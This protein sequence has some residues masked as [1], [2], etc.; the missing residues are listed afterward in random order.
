MFSQVQFLYSLISGQEWW[1]ARLLAFENIFGWGLSSTHT[2]CWGFHSDSSHV[3]FMALFRFVESRLHFENAGAPE[4]IIRVKSNF[5]RIP[6]SR[7]RFWR[8][9][10][11]ES[12]T[13]YISFTRFSF[14]EKDPLDCRY[15]ILAYLGIIF[16]AS[17]EPLY[18][19]N[20]KSN[21][22]WA[23]VTLKVWW[24]QGAQIFTSAEGSRKFWIGNEEMKEE[25]IA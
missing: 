12:K 20:H 22:W 25:G 6:N 19:I 13:P 10:L 23:Q 1:D 14:P 4:F 7:Y 3:I 17:Y 18:C 24:D 5:D 2:S 16:L 11:L 15:S 8:Q 9:N 21:C